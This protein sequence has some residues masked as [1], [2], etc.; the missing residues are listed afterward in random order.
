MDTTKTAKDLA[1][2]Q[3]FYID[4]LASVREAIEL[5]REKNV[6]ALIIRKRNEAD[7][8]GIVTASDIIK[9]VIIPDKTIDEVSI[10]EIMTKPVLSIPASL[11]AKYVPRLMYNAKIRVAPVE[12]NGVYIGM[13]NYSSFLYQSC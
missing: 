8:N 5:M 11:N 6:Q 4:G 13:I 10:Y 9:G 7:A 3:L 12:E 1:T 2:N